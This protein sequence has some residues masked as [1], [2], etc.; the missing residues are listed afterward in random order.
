MPSAPPSY[1]ESVNA[2]KYM[3]NAQQNDPIYPQQPPME[4]YQPTQVVVVQV[5][6]LPPLGD[7]SVEVTCPTCKAVVL[8]RVDEE[9][10]S[11]A[12]LCCML[13]FIVGCALC[14]CVP[15]CMDNFKNYKHSCPRCN[16]FIGS[17]RPV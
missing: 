1:S 9:A 10:S 4:S 12:Y 2:Q 7:R 8:T 11:G 5:P 17:Y 3:T 14:S 15:F 13:M 6:G 16:A